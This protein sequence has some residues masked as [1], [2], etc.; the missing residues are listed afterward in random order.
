MW[1]TIKQLL[2]L[3]LLFLFVVSN[4]IQ[5]TVM[6]GSLAVQAIIEPHL[7]ANP[8]RYKF[9]D[10]KEL[11]PSTNVCNVSTSNVPAFAPTVAVQGL[12]I[13]T[14][15][16]ECAAC[17][18]KLKTIHRVTTAL[19]KETKMNSLLIL[20]HTS[21]I[22]QKFDSSTA[23]FAFAE[24]IP[25]NLANSACEINIS[26]SG[27]PEGNS[28]GDALRSFSKTSVL[29]VSISFI[30]LMVISLAWLVFYYVQR[31]RY[32]HAKDRMQRRLFNAA[33]KA[34]AKIP[35]RQLRQ[36]D[37]QL[38]ADCP[39]C[40]DPYNVGDVIRTL[41]CRH[42]FHKTCVDPWLLEHRTCPMCKQDILKAFGMN[43]VN[44]SG[45]RRPHLSSSTSPGDPTNRANSQDSDH[46]SEDETNSDSQ[47]FPYPTSMGNDIQDPFGFTPST[48]PQLVM[49]AKNARGFSIIPLTVHS[50]CERP[51]TQPATL[52]SEDGASVSTGSAT[53][54]A[55]SS[56]V[57]VVPANSS[58]GHVVNLVHVRSRS[59]T[60]NAQERPATVG[61]DMI[62][63]HPQT[64]ATF[65]APRNSLPD[66]DVEAG[67][68]NMRYSAQAMRRIDTPA[69]QRVGTAPPRVRTLVPVSHP[70]TPPQRSPLPFA[71]AD[72]VSAE[73][74]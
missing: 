2:F 12:D 53:G 1:T 68:S 34:L 70:H 26:P 30:I 7:P 29:F 14:R 74:I 41:P 21:K 44:S 43:I 37:L 23:S 18:D 48:S 6:C 9:V 65:R 42:I 4:A 57:I 54:S 39:V 71:A 49:H 73:S 72:C 46:G 51:S 47:Q 33:K 40:I 35:T 10:I 69:V 27:G 32:A 24:S 66:R 50:T 15:C 5:Q 19:A 55:S 64:V 61:G 62:V 52:P 16:D 58:K 63:H 28:E 17:P 31:F 22:M 25:H 20:V 59:L 36:G 60:Q 56:R 67:H 8:I 3:V 13:L 38:D 45:R 11:L